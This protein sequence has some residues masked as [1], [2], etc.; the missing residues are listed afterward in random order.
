MH[1]QI[2]LKSERAEEKKIISEMATIV[3]PSQT[4]K[5]VP[6]VGGTASIP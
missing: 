5:V 3:P 4:I 1:A 6:L 2:F